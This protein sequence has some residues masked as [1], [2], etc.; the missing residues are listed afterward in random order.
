GAFNL[1]ALSCVED[2]LPS[3]GC[4]SPSSIKGDG[5]GGYFCETPD[6]VEVD[7]C[8]GGTF[9]A[10]NSI[11][12]VPVAATCSGALKSKVGELTDTRTIYMKVGSSLANFTYDNLTTAQKTTFQTS[13]LSAN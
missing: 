7:A 1:T 6:V 10:E 2:V 8:E 12:R 3:S 4:T 11:C 9:D 5:L 13:F